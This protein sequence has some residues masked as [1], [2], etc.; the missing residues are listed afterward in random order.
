MRKQYYRSPKIKI[1]VDKATKDLKKLL[2]EEK[3]QADKYISATSVPL[4]HLITLYE[5]L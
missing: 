2:S 3:M 4:K 1:R 5:R